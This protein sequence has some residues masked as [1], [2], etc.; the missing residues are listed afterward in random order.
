MTIHICCNT[1]QKNEDP[2]AFCETSDVDTLTVNLIQSI[3]MDADH[4]TFVDKASD[5]GISL[6][7]LKQDQDSDPQLQEIIAKL[8]SGEASQCMQSKHLLDADGVLHF[9]AD[10]Y[11][12]IQ[13]VIFLPQK[14][15]KT[16]LTVIHDNLG[17][18]GVQ[19]T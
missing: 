9:I 5:I 13:P 12:H 3:A 17:H 16:V 19:C 14:Y 4:N 8:L 10:I 15:R 1:F 7:T 18:L 11:G 6:K 2:C